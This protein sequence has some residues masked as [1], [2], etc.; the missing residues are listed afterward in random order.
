MKK[1]KI[2]AS[3]IILLLTYSSHSRPTL[4][5]KSII[6][7]AV[8][9]YR[10]YISSLFND[11]VLSDENLYINTTM[12]AL[13]NKRRKSYFQCVMQWK[14]ITYSWKM[15]L[16]LVDKIFIAYVLPLWY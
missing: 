4:R 3:Q 2:S 13:Y 11:D 12:H 15:A 7:N 1:F 5:K 14:P 6:I 16:N 8:I 9:T 10:L